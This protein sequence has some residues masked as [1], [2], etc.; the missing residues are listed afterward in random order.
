M[1]TIIMKSSIIIIIIL[2]KNESLIN[3]SSKTIDH[4]NIHSKFYFTHNNHISYR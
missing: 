1:L 2:M 3:A 4:T